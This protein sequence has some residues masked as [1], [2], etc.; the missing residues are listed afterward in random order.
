MTIGNPAEID[1]DELIRLTQALVRI[2]SVYRPGEPGGTEAEVALFI[3][4]YLRKLG[5]EVF[6]EEAAPGRPN[7]IGRIRGRGPGKTLLFEGHTDVVTAG[8]SGRWSVDPFGGELLDG[9]IYGRGA[10]DTKG[11]TA[12]MIL[13]AKALLD[14]GR[15]FPGT[16]LLCIPVDEEGM[17]IGIK[18]FIRQGWARG[19]DGAIICEP[20]EN[21]ICVAQ[22]GALRIRLDFAGKMAHGAMPYAG[23]NPIPRLAKFLVNVEQWEERE[24]RRLGRHP[25]LGVPHITPTIVRAPAEGEAQV[26]V[27]PGEATVFLDLRTVPGQDHERLVADVRGILDSLAA[28]DPDFSASFQVLDDRPCTETDPGDPVVRAVAEAYRAVTGREPVYNGVP[29]ATDGTFLHAWAGIPVV[30]TGAGSRTLPHQVDEYV[31]VEELAIT[32]RMYAEAAR[33]FLAGSGAGES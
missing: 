15:D 32:A 23:I 19:V 30:T 27:V 26:N 9:R 28:G 8:D 33:R 7:V 14:A 13:A 10:C 11:N 17:M 24:V 12:A 1:Q 25:Y 3:A 6:V 29:G 4:D 5:V 22:K 16:I 21:Q 2:P 18:H 20:E 31:D